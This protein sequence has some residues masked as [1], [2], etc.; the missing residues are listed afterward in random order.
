MHLLQECPGAV[1]ADLWA[2]GIDLAAAPETMSPLRCANILASVPNGS[3][4]WRE[5]GGWKALTDV[6]LASVQNVYAH[7]MA[8]W[9]SGGQKGSKAPK[10]P[11]PPVGL[12]EERKT[13]AKRQE[14][15]DV[16]AV[17]WTERLEHGGRELIEARLAEWGSGWKTQVN[18]SRQ[19]ESARRLA[20][21]TQP[22]IEQ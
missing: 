19:A 14:R 15:F 18:D 16:K 1:D 9:A 22:V 17:E 6:E 13:R 7:S 21:W 4:I 8:I 10:P 3:R 5:I 11:V 12:L 20:S 2:A